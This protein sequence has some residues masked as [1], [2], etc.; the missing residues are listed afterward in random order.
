VATKRGISREAAELYPFAENRAA[1]YDGAKKAVAAI[2][3][4]KPYR[5]E[6]PIKA[7]KQHLIYEGPDKGKVVT[8]EG[9]IDDVLHLLDF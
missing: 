9:M 4:C 6:T 5:L 1:L 3:R 7:K 8:K 2:P